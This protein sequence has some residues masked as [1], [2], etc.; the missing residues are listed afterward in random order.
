[1]PPPRSEVHLEKTFYDADAIFPLY[2]YGEWRTQW[3]VDFHITAP[4][5]YEIDWPSASR[6]MERNT[7]IKMATWLPNTK[8]KMATWL[9]YWKSD[10]N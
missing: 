4:L 8:I 9:P 6:V 3:C 2:G 7:K 5:K 10:R 1:M